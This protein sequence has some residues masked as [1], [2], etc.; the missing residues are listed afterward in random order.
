LDFQQEPNYEYL[1]SLFKSIMNKNNYSYDFLFDWTKTSKKED[2]LSM[3]NKSIKLMQSQNSNGN[4][5]NKNINLNTISNY[6]NLNTIQY[7]NSLGKLNLNVNNDNTN[8]NMFLNNVSS[9]KNSQQN[10]LSKSNSK[11]P[12]PIN[13]ETTAKF[14]GSNYNYNYPINNFNFQRG[15]IN[16]L[17]SS[18][19]NFMEIGPKTN[20]NDA[21]PSL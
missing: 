16:N 21:F 12:R 7:T 11:I 17:S 5:V 19:I 9:A 14:S 15:S 18:K 13:F 4:L 10:F 20:K 8:I 1:R 6:N 3:S 2:K